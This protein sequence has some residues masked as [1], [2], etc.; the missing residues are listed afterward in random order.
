M[1]GGPL[2]DDFAAKLSALLAPDQG[3]GAAAVLEKA[4]A[5]PDED[6]A[7]FLGAVAERVRLSAAP[8]TAGELAALLDSLPTP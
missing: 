7:A 5:L 4:L 3:E 1:G 2:P 6:L 8:I